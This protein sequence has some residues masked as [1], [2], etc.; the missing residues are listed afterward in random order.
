MAGEDE[1]NDQKSDGLTHA[2]ISAVKASPELNKAFYLNPGASHVQSKVDSRLAFFF[3]RRQ[4]LLRE[5]KAVLHIEPNEASRL[6][7]LVSGRKRT[8]FEATKEGLGRKDGLDKA[9]GRWEQSRETLLSGEGSSGSRSQEQ[10]D[11]NSLQYAIS[12]VAYESR[13][14]LERIAAR[15]PCCKGFTFRASMGEIE[16]TAPGLRATVLVMPSVLGTAFTF[17]AQYE[18]EQNGEKESIGPIRLSE[19]SLW[20]LIERMACAVLNHA[21]RAERHHKRAAIVRLVAPQ[22]LPEGHQGLREV[23]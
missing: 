12:D 2:G 22:K 9:I 3:F 13:G 4:E 23:A 20:L 8:P 18:S 5:E 21:P 6:V 10:L 14:V 16:V 15:N 17:T 7:E 1:K 11:F 19:V